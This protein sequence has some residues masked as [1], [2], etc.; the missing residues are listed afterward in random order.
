M[1]GWARDEDVATLC[2]DVGNE[3]A[4]AIA[5]YKR[6]GFKPTGETSVFPPPREHIR[7]HRMSVQL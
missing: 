5:L 4:P 6:K 1:I 3:N 7:E 2:L